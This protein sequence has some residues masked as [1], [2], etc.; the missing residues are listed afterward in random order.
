MIWFLLS[1]VASGSNPFL[2]ESPICVVEGILDDKQ[3]RRLIMT[4]AAYVKELSGMLVGI[5]IVCE[6]KTSVSLMISV[7]VEGMTHVVHL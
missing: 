6:M 3:M 4:D 5:R 2:V 1:N 7:L